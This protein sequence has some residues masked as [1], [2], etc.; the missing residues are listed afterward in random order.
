MLLGLCADKT[1]PQNGWVNCSS[2]CFISE[3]GFLPDFTTLPWLCF[4][5]CADRCVSLEALWLISACNLT[6]FQADSLSLLWHS[7]HLFKMFLHNICPRFF[8]H[9]LLQTEC[10]FVTWLRAVFPYASQW[11]VEHAEAG[12]VTLYLKETFV[13]V[14]DGKTLVGQ[15]SKYTKLP[16]EFYFCW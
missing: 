16:W 2:N 10:S 12:A 15:L 3:L 14:I 6:S 8:L 5:P 1:D 9:L 13:C 11:L 4:E 7:V